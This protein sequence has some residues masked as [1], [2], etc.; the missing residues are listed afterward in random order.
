MSLESPS[1]GAFW[2]HRKYSP[3]KDFC[4]LVAETERVEVEEKKKKMKKK[5]RGGKKQGEKKRERK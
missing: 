1:A 4:V 2:D 3:S 5:K